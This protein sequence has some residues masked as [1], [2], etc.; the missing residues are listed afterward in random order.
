MI[1]PALASIMV[2]SYN[3]VPSLYASIDPNER[4]LEVTT[5][6]K[7]DEKRCRVMERLSVDRICCGDDRLREPECAF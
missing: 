2:N 4:L 7:R 6:P 5:I 3:Y 1:N